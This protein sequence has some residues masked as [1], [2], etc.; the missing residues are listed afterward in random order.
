MLKVTNIVVRSFDLDHLDLFWEI[1]HTTESLEA[2]DLFLLRSTDGMAGPYGVIAGPFYNQYMFRDPNVQQLHKW[3]TYFY[4]IRVVHRET[5]TQAEYGPQWLQAEPDRIA[6]EVQR[7]EGLMFKEHIGRAVVY[8]PA[9]TFGQRCAHCWD[10]NERGNYIGRA[11]QQ[12]CETCYDTTFVGGYGTPVRIYM[13][14]D[15]SPKTVQ[16]MDTSEKQYVET[17]ARTTAYPPLKPKDLIVEAENK[18]WRV[19]SPVNRTEKLRATIRQELKLR[20]YPPGDIKFKVP[21]TIDVQ[22]DFSPPRE[23]SR[24]MTVPATDPTEAQGPYSQPQ[25]EGG[26]FRWWEGRH[27]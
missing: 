4:K 9:L 16:L 23:Y 7:R 17:T 20:E 26:E 10:R 21:V 25:I 27:D 5:Q 24:P 15:P 14:I 2:Y 18:R 6:L 8:F 1:E 12:N 19:E 11:T 22:S 13:Q 3:R